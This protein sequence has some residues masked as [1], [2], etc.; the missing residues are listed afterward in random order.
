M[1]HKR[2]VSGLVLLLLGLVSLI[3]SP[4][5]FIIFRWLDMGLF[6][7]VLV[8]SVIVMVAGIVLTIK[9]IMPSGYS[10]NPVRGVRMALDLKDQGSI[11]AASGPFCQKCGTLN[12]KGANFCKKCGASLN[13][14]EAFGKNSNASNA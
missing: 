13:R 7:P 4:F 6:I 5:T 2:F 9:S 3:S 1:R 8:A 11:S 14:S 12:E 10:M